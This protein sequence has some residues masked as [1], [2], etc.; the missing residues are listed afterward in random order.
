ML[1]IGDLVVSFILRWG[2]PSKAGWPKNG[3]SLTNMACQHS[4]GVQNGPKL[5][6]ERF[7]I[8]RDRFGPIWYAAIAHWKWPLSSPKGL[9]AESARAVTGR[10][11]PYSAQCVV[12]KVYFSAQLNNLKL[13]LNFK[14]TILLN[15]YL[16]QLVRVRGKYTFL[17]F[18]DFQTLDLWFPPK[19]V[20]VSTTGASRPAKYATVSATGA[21]T[22]SRWPVCRSAQGNLIMT[23]YLIPGAPNMSLYLI[24]G[25]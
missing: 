14:N 20:T 2:Q 11:C 16:S 10:R 19:Y 9:R 15:I 8:M 1:H 3:Q 17:S 12:C 7:L 6:T 22:V 13:I 21:C 18:S 25:P 4:I 24:P 23:L 5:S